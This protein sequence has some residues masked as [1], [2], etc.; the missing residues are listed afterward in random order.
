M[1]YSAVQSTKPLINHSTVLVQASNGSESQRVRKR[2]PVRRIGPRIRVKFM[3]GFI[4][5]RAIRPALALALVSR[6]GA[7]GA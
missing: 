5:L 3:L 4:P 6:N 7:V 2:G 1:R